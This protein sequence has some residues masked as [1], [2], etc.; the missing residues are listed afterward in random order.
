MEKCVQCGALAREH[1]I[2]AIMKLDETLGMEALDF[3]G[4]DNG[5]MAM[6]MCAKCHQAPKLKAHY[7]LRAH[8]GQG[9]AHA[10]SSDLG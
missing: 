1:P 3:G 6:A 5:F 9:L 4:V 8:L 2:V 10:G 7:H